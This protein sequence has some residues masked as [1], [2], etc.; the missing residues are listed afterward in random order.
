MVPSFYFPSILG[1]TKDC[2]LKIVNGVIKDWDVTAFSSLTITGSTRHLHTMQ[3]RSTWHPFGPERAKQLTSALSA[4]MHVL[5][6]RDIH[7]FAG[8]RRKP[9]GRWAVGSYCLFRFFKNPLPPGPRTTSCFVS[10]NYRGYSIMKEIMTK[11]SSMEDEGVPSF[12]YSPA[13]A[14]M[15]LLFSLQ[16]PLSALRTSLL[17]T[18]AGRE[19][20]TEDYIFTA[21][22]DSSHSLKDL[23]NANEER[24]H[25]RDQVHLN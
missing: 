4:R 2:H 18:Y 11:E 25:G 10:K 3:L 22:T 8:N 14:T 24:S 5:H 23:M 9:S 21:S 19:L 17:Q 1:A 20:T 12:T 15:P 6:T 16:Q 7:D 13:D